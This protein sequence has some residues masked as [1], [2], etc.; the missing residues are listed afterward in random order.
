MESD[1]NLKQKGD[2]IENQEPSN[3]EL[4]FED[5]PEPTQEAIIDLFVSIIKNQNR[6]KLMKN[7]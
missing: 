2:T 4:D 5:L 6:K 1:N 7:K 3:M